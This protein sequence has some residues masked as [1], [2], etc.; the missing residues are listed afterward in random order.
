VLKKRE[1]FGDGKNLEIFALRAN[2]K[3]DNEHAIE[4]YC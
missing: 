4:V 3:C 2:D 1:A